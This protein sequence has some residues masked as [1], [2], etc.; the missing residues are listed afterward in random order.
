M[1]TRSVF[2]SELWLHK[3]I[4]PRSLVVCTYS[5]ELVRMAASA[6]PVLPPARSIM[7]RTEPRSA[8]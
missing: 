7:L 4:R 6:Q 2:A 5:G 1:P 3:G 8:G